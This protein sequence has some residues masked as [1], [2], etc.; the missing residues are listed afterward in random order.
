QM[1]FTSRGLSIG[2]IYSLILLISSEECLWI[3]KMT[4]RDV[5]MNVV[6]EGLH[7][8]LLVSAHLESNERF[9]ECRLLYSLRVP[10]GMYFDSDNVNSSL[11]NH[12]MYSRHYFDVEAPA[13]DSKEVQISIVST[14][15]KRKQFIITDHF[16]VPI[17]VRYHSPDA[18]GA[19]TV[20]PP[21]LLIDC[22]A[23][24]RIH[25]LQHCPTASAKSVRSLAEKWV[26]IDPLTVSAPVTVSIPTGNR[27]MLPTVVTV[28]FA[29]VACSLLFL[30]KSLF[31][32]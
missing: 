31:I 8:N 15:M 1:G 26:I 18:A 21:R 22:P 7:R 20:H 32:S 17:H 5:K 24:Y 13:K 3:Q 16:S 27:S 10:Q 11:P 29:V 30:A 25:S 19:A 28:T 6:G 2:V 9:V 23:D 14:R 4:K 12:A